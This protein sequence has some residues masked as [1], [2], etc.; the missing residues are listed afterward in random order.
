MG[1]AGGV[2]AP[3]GNHRDLRVIDVEAGEQ[4]RPGR[5]GHDHDGVG[6]RAHLLQH[7]LLVRGRFGQDGVGHHHDRRDDG[8]D[9]LDQRLAVGP[10]VQAVLVLHDDEIVAVQR[11]DRYRP[12]GPHPVGERRH[13]QHVFNVGREAAANHFDRCAIGDQTGRERGR[14]GSDPT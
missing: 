5:L 7:E 14:E 2:A 13:H 9:Q 8:V 10:V 3:C 4:P 1:A 12:A 6:G 11:I